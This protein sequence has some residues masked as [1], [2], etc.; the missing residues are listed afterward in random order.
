MISQPRPI[1][2]RRAY[3]SLCETL[4]GGALPVLRGIDQSLGFG[5]SRMTYD[6]SERG[7]EVGRLL[8]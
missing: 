4:H 6:F 3:Q 1:A 2:D 5:P 8:R 7:A